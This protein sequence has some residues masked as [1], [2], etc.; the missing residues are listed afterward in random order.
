MLRPTEI[1][2]SARTT[3]HW[4]ARRLDAGAAIGAANEVAARLRRDIG[5][6][7]IAAHAPSPCSRT[8]SIT[9]TS[10]PVPERTPLARM[11]T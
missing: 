8:M 4:Q 7:T 10:H 1:K 5:L 9:P 3:T 11:P 2:P 6:L